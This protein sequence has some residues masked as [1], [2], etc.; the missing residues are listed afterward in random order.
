MDKRTKL[1]VAAVAV[2]VG[3]V[4]LNNLRSPERKLPP[5][6]QQQF[7]P[8]ADPSPPIQEPPKQLTYEEA[9]NTITE[10]ELKK[11]LYYLAS[12]ELEGRMSGKKGN[13]T[14]ATFLKE[15]HEENGLP[16][17]YQQF[18][19]RRVNPG[20]HNE[21]GDSFTKNIFASI[22]GVGPLKDEVVVLGAHMDHIGYGPSMSRSR[23]R[24]K[25]HPGADDNASGTVVVMQVAQAL[26]HFKGRL[27]RTVVFQHY[28]AEEM[29]LIGARY[30]CD[31]P[32]FPKSGPSIKKH[33]AMVNLD[34]VGYLNRGFYFAGFHSGDSS[35]DIGRYINE[36]NNKYTFARRITSRGSGG[37][38]H[39]CFYNKRVPVAF[40]H[41]GS[42][43]HYHT[44][45]DTA[46]KLNYEGMERVA[47][48]TF[49]LVWKIIH[50]DVK[51]AFNHEEFKAMEFK[52]DHGHPD[53]PFY[54]HSY[55][56]DE[57][58]DHDH[59]HPHTHP[60]PED[61]RE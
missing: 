21:E 17:E 26:S 34:M 60:Y 37:S 61:R 24:N 52:H 29:G 56:L 46:D 5:P 31:N 18:N 45:T 14:A 1:I 7:P 30:Y 12:D 39:A 23:S 53:V 54:R 43:S 51:P 4:I 57:W 49:E 15:F 2:V 16:T 38:D 10:A 13:V 9:L 50:A 36:L 6:P 58:D 20:P 3:L 40:L 48:Y 25:I 35:L 44:P 32:T 33:I 42:H 19:I 27:P 47:K 8:I 59:T 55:H 11:D 22:E 41:T 28:S